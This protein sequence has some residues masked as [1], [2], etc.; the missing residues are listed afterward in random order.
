M[1][2]DVQGNNYDYDTKAG[3]YEEEYYEEEEEEVEDEG[4]GEGEWDENEEEESV[5]ADDEIELTHEEIWDDTALI[6]AWDEAVRQYEVYHSKTGKNEQPSKSST[7]LLNSKTKADATSMKR[8]R[9]DIS[10]EEST[11]NT[12]TISPLPSDQQLENG[13]AVEDAETAT[14]PESSTLESEYTSLDRKPSFKKA[15]KPVFNHYKVHKEQQQADRKRVKLDHS[16]SKESSKVPAAALRPAATQSVDAA[17]IEYYRQLGYY[18]DPEYDVSSGVTDQAEQDPATDLRRGPGAATSKSNPST[19]APTPVGPT[20]SAAA[21]Y[22]SP[23]GGHLGPHHAHMS[24]GYPHNVASVGYPPAYPI[25]HM[26]G[27]TTGGVPMPGMT[28]PG[29][30]LPAH[31]APG[32]VNNHPHNM[33]PPMPMPMPMPPSMPSGGPDDETLSNLMMAWYF[34]GYYTGLYQAQRK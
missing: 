17:T 27:V 4:H 34:S 2:T 21:T 11:T 16:K 12:T 23:L 13:E 9:S 31:A 19:F 29:M 14:V 26:P 10:N 7:I 22:P 25:T 20:M 33:I 18:Y 5:N 32:F 6:E 1:T 30:G 28:F 15:D 3:E 24:P 8:I